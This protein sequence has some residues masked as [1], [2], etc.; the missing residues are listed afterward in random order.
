MTSRRPPPFS[1][2]SCTTL[3]TG[4]MKTCSS[5]LRLM[6][7]LVASVLL[8]CGTLLLAAAVFFG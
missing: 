5:T 6:A 3:H 4:D 8:A 2:R 7:Q 1:L